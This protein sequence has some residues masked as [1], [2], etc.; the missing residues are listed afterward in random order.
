MR[1]TTTVFTSGNSQAVRLPKAFRLTAKTVEIYRRGDEIV[2]REKRQFLGKTLADLF[3]G[4][5][6]LTAAEAAEFE[7]A[8]AAGRDT[9]APQGR[10]FSWMSEPVERKTKVSRRKPQEQGDQGSPVTA[11]SPRTGEPRFPR[12]RFKP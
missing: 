9:R 12:Y 3:A 4:L 10:D 6:E 8:I 5:P 11:S 2:L 1:Q 7:A